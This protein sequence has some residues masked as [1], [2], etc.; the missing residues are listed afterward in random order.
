MKL[1]RFEA[2]GRVDLGVVEGAGERG[3]VIALG[4]EFPD[5][6]ALI[7]G[8]EAALDEVRAA[9]AGRSP[10]HKLSDVRLLAPLRPGKYLAIGMNYADHVAEMKH[11]GPPAHQYWFNKQTT[12]VSG[13][14]DQIAPGVSEMVDYEV[15]LGVVIGRTAKG[16]SAADALHH[17]FGYFVANDV[18]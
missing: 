3:G 5:M 13:P 2:N 11:D 12:C 17:V 6:L 15:E 16:V 18:S 10:D 4:F 9:V 7:E 14:Y 1:A 8:G